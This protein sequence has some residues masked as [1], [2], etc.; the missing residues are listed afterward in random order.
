MEEGEGGVGR[1]QGNFGS[2][3]LSSCKTPGVKYG[4]DNEYRILVIIKPNTIEDIL[5]VTV[6]IF[7]ELLPLLKGSSL[8]LS[9]GEPSRHGFPQV[10]DPRTKTKLK[11]HTRK[12]RNRIA[13]NFSFHLNSLDI[14]QLLNVF[15]E[16]E[17][18]TKTEEERR[19][20]MSTDNIRP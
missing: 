14:S 7:F 16:R 2:V 12:S 6:E 11:Q 3:F 17:R 15:K 4:Y 18:E 1:Q 8:E 19:E 10:S 5:N 20:G 13:R 9:F